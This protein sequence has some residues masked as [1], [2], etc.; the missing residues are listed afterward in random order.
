[1]KCPL[2]KLELDY[3]ISY[4]FISI[5]RILRQELTSL[6]IASSDKDPYVRVSIPS[7]PLFLFKRYLCCDIESKLCIL[8]GL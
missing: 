7:L 8:R 3:V 5:D 6:M 4:L 2:C 1:M